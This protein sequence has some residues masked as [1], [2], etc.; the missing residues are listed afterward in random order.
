M[1]ADAW[2]PR[3]PAQIDATVEPVWALVEELRMLK[4]QQSILQHIKGVR[5]QLASRIGRC[6]AA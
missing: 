4:A 3:T 6:C 1:H 5:G 2:Q